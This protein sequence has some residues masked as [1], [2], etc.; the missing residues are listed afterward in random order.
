MDEYGYEFLGIG[1]PKCAYDVIEG[2][3]YNWGSDNGSQVR[4]HGRA[5]WSDPFAVRRVLGHGATR[6]DASR[7]Y[8]LARSL[9]YHPAVKGS[10]KLL[11]RRFSLDVVVRCPVQVFPRRLVVASLARFQ[12]SQLRASSIFVDFDLCKT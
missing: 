1:D 7:R 2:G 10:N 5:Q 11:D 9:A 12:T 4:V 8:L 6:L 3:R